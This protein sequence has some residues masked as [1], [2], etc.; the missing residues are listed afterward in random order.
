[1]LLVGSQR[2]PFPAQQLAFALHF[3]QHV[4][5]GFA[6]AQQDAGRLARRHAVGQ[7]H[8]PVG[9]GKG[10]AGGLRI[11]EREIEPRPGRVAAGGT[12][13]EAVA[14][15]GHVGQQGGPGQ[16]RAAVGIE[17]Q[18]F[19]E[20]RRGFVVGGFGRG[21]GHAGRVGLVAAGQQAQRA[22]G[23]QRLAGGVGAQQREG[24][25]VLLVD[26]GRPHQAQTERVAPH[27]KAAGAGAGFAGRI[28][29]VGSYF[30]QVPRLPA[31]A[32]PRRVESQRRREREAEAAP[33]IGRGGAVGHFLATPVAAG[34][35]AA[36]PAEAVSKQRPQLA[37]R[38]AVAHRRPVGGRPGVGAGAAR[39]GQGLAQ[40]RPARHRIEAD[41]E[42]GPLVVLHGEA[43]AAVVGLQA[44][45]AV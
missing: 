27:G 43:K 29:H 8:K 37:A 4:R 33:G 28:G 39:Q 20:R 14:A 30:K 24:R 5:T 2:Q 11:V 25:Q 35:V 44:H 21:A 1:M 34:H 16:L 3:E 13:F 38:D 40:L 12:G 41:E 42:G 9:R 15:G 31:P 10:H 6:A 17:G 45:F 23:G 36:A 19:E 32:R 18:R 22:G 26:F 7:G